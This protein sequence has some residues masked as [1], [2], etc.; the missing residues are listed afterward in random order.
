M[1]NFLHLPIWKEEHSS[2]YKEI[3]S[4][5]GQSDYEDDTKRTKHIATLKSEWETAKY[6]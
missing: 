3:V 2:I 6:K 4:R 5:Y 1:K